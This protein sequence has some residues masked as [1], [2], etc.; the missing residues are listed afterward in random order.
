MSGKDGDRAK[1]W[2]LIKETVDL[3]DPVPYG[4]YLGCGQ[5][6]GEGTPDSKVF[7]ACELP[8]VERNTT[9]SAKVRTMKYDMSSFIF[10]VP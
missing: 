8:G 3:E 9:P 5:E 6:F 1:A 2:K 7:K 10:T 4:R